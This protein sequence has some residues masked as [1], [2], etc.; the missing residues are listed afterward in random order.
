MSTHYKGRPSPAGSGAGRANPGE[1][2]RRALAALF[3][4][5]VTVG[6]YLPAL[7]AGFVWD[8]DKYVTD[9]RTLRTIDGLE[10]IW[11][12]P[13]ALPQY[14]PLVW[15][16]SC[17]KMIVGVRSPQIACSLIIPC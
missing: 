2:R 17:L 7:S 13:L 15:G 10:V 3:L 4:V 12:Q 9:N 6:A 11:S 5:I 1:H 8:D 14:Y 16:N